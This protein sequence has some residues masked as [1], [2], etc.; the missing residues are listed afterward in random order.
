[1]VGL[2]TISIVLLLGVAPCQEHY[3]LFNKVVE[4]VRLKFFFCQLDHTVTTFTQNYRTEH[5]LC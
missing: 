4:F 3:S 5:F 1:M 2:L